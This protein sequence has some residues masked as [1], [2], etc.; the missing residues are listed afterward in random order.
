MAA[1][2]RASVGEGESADGGRNK[3]ATP[4]SYDGWRWKGFR[5]C[6]RETGDPAKRDGLDN[7]HITRSRD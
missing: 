4:A 1:G 6:M 2:L 7:G 3:P 5:V